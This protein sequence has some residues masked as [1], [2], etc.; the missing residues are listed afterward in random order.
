M[1][2]KLK[3]SIVFLVFLVAVPLFTAS[4]FAI[5]RPFLKNGERIFDIHRD[6]QILGEA[7]Y[8]F[9]RRDGQLFVRIDLNYILGSAANPFYRLE[10]HSE[11]VWESGRLKAMISDTEENGVRW[12]LRLDWDG[13]QLNGQSNEVKLAVSGL[14]IPSSLWHRDT[15]K[16]ET[17]VSSIDGYVRPLLVQP[18]GRRQVPVAGRSTQ[19]DGYVLFGALERTVWYDDECQLIHAS[20]NAEDGREVFWELRAPL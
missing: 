2:S 11:E 10:H 1:K 17:L 14:A 9:D 8:S 16:S 5:C 3:L 12:R 18:L 19:A 15:P 7:R 13:E 20:H 6:D 4:A